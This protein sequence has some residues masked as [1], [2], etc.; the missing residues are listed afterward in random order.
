MI[1]FL[2]LPP[3]SNIKLLEDCRPRQSYRYLQLGEGRELERR[4]DAANKGSALCSA[5]P[6]GPRSNNDP[7][8]GPAAP[9]PPYPRHTGASSE[10]QRAGV[11]GMQQ[12]RAQYRH[13]SALSPPSHRDRRVAAPAYSGHHL[14]AQAAPWLSQRRHAAVQVVAA[15]GS[16]QDDIDN[17][18]PEACEA[19]GTVQE[20]EAEAWEYRRR[21]GVALFSFLGPALTIPLADPLM[22]LVDTVCIG[23]FADTAQLAGLGPA[24]LVFAFVNYMWTSQGVTT[25]ALVAKALNVGTVRHFSRAPLS[26]CC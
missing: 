1:I 22:S 7:R 14:P 13:S 18:L 21:T 4:L 10:A 15:I 9:K 16:G 5:T 8:P 6:N 2:P 23:R 17:S 3:R 26:N 24:A 20:A 12:V 25:T 11:G 19:Q